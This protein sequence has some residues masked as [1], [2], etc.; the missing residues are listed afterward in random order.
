MTRGHVDGT[1]EHVSRSIEEDT[2]FTGRDRFSH[3]GWEIFGFFANS[4]NSGGWV[5]FAGALSA[6][7]RSLHPDDQRK[8]Q[9][10]G[11]AR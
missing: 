5:V 10:N 2:A 3:D 8:G 6:L 9:G 1:Q 7:L 11:R 4:K